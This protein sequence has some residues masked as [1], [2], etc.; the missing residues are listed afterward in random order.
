MK[1]LFGAGNYI[2][3]N[4][5][6]SR[7]LQNATKHEIRIAAFYRNHKYL[8]HI[9][10]CLDAVFSSKNGEDYFFERTGYH[11][12]D[13]DSY[14]T[15]IIVGDLLEWKPDLIISDCESFTAHLSKALEIPLW[16]CSPMLQLVGI[17]HDRKE[18]N[19]KI[20]DIESAYLKTL[21]KAEK[22]L[23][24]SPLCDIASRPFLRNGFEWVRPY[25]VVPNEVS[26]EDDDFSII[27]K[28]IPYNSL[29]TTGETSFIS[30]CLYSGNKI[31]VSPNPVEI[32]QVLNAQLFEYYGAGINIGRPKNINFLKS[33]V[34]R[35]C[36]V[37]DLSIQN[38]TQ[39]D[40]KLE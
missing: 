37:A 34:E 14:I 29:F 32:E 6:V 17:E 23:V 31:Y 40:E 24:Y 35:H 12:P 28:S 5:M 15:D 33:Q 21:P 18:I 26:T 2:G 25:S 36:P 19:S 30:D 7:F 22:Y 39:L 1:I 38:W 10:W 20:M 4:V 13:V 9:D 8:D 16:Y 27:K 3:S 11:G